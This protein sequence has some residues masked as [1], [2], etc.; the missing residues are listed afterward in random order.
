[1]RSHEETQLK[2]REFS[3]GYAVICTEV[4]CVVHARAPRGSRL[5][6]L[7]SCP[8]RSKHLTNLVEEQEREIP[9]T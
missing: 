2:L 5:Q 6:S 9:Q 1:M 4:L 3:S 8:P 7:F